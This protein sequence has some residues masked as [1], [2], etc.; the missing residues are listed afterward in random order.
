MIKIL[1]FSEVTPEQ[2]FARVENTVNVEAVVSEIIANV[3]KNGDKAL[4]EYCEKF[5][6]A[7]LDSLQ[8]TQDEISEAVASVDPKFLEILRR[9]AANIRKFHEAQVRRSFIINDE[10]GIVMST[11]AGILV[12]TGEGLHIGKLSLDGGELHVDGK[13]DAVLYEDR[14][15]PRSSL[16]GRLFG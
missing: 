2:V 13:I 15:A 10:T 14:S 11:T 16:L 7:K 9:A 8:V 3:R 4:Y 5:D 6:R 12:I 1:N